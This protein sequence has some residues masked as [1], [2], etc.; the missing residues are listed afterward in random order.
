MRG[1]KKGPVP[2]GTEPLFQI[3][4]WSHCMPTEASV[5]AQGLHSGF[6]TNAT[7]LHRWRRVTSQT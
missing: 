2:F 1:I 5:P 6:Q 3:P 4:L 7:F